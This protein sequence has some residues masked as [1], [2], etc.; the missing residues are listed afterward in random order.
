VEKSGLPMREFCRRK[1]IP[2]NN[3]YRRIHLLDTLSTNVIDFVLKQK[4]DESISFRLLFDVSQKIKAKQ[5]D[6]LLS[7]L[8]NSKKN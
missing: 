3:F 6:I 5:L 8:N 7:R 1:N 4:D 2:F